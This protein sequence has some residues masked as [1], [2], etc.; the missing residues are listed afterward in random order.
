M[1]R[2]DGL[3]RLPGSM[4]DGIHGLPPQQRRNEPRGTGHGYCRTVCPCHRVATC[5]DRRC[6][7]S[8]P[9]GHPGHDRADFRGRVYPEPVEEHVQVTAFGL[10]GP[11]LQPRVR[12]GPRGSMKLITPTR[13][14]STADLGSELPHPSF[15]GTSSI[16]WKFK[17]ES[18]RCIQLS[19]SE[20]HAQSAGRRIRLTGARKCFI[21]PL[22]LL[23]RRR[24]PG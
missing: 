19:V 16:S 11:R 23:M 10:P 17:P 2:E 6:C 12:I 20:L 5:A 1:G 7:L 15:Q 21:A 13:C 4:T 22:V 3:L 18:A 14:P 24:S 9:G 8:T